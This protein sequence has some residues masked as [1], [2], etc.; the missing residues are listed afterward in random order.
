[1]VVVNDAKNESLITVK[2]KDEFVTRRC[3]VIVNLSFEDL[4]LNI[5]ITKIAAT[6]ASMMILV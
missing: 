3:R 4:I 6:V 5:D 1:M 2:H